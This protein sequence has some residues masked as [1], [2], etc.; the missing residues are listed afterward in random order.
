MVAAVHEYER[1]K[2]EGGHP[3]DEIIARVGIGAPMIATAMP[4]YANLGHC[5]Q[6]HKLLYF[7]LKLRFHEVGIGAPE[8][9]ALTA[10]G[11]SFSFY[12]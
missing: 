3:E 2:K 12:G 9:P 7:Q 6:T 5:L 8:P 1:L 4:A 11:T 10:A